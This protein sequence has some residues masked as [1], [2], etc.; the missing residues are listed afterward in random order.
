MLTSHDTM[1]TQL[2]SRLA[3]ASQPPAPK[4]QRTSARLRNSLAEPSKQRITMTA[5][6]SMLVDAGLVRRTV[7]RRRSVRPS[8]PSAHPSFECPR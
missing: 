6:T 5:W 3:A 7:V 2:F 1:L 4:G 8:R